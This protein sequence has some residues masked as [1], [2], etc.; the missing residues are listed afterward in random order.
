MVSYFNSIHVD[1]LQQLNVVSEELIEVVDARGRIRCVCRWLER[2]R[3]GLCTV[4][5]VG[6]QRRR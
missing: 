3:A 6:M 1:S 5:R 4:R 2:C